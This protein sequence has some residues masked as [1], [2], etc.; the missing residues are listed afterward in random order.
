MS[1]DIHSESRIDT[2]V[3]PLERAR[4]LLDSS[5]EAPG[6][7]ALAHCVGLSPSHLQ[8]RFRARFGVS[9]AE[10][11]AA[12]KLGRFKRS[13]RDGNDVTTAVY[14]AGFGSGSRVYE[15]TDRLLGMT[16]A[17]Y[18]AGGADVAVRYTTLETPL[19]RLL[20]AATERGVCAVA[21]GANDAALLREL[22]DELPKARLDRVDEGSDDWLAAVIAHVFAQLGWGDAP[23]A[24]LPPLDLRASAFQWRVWQA[25]T[26]IP[27]GQTR[28]YSEIAHDIGAPRAARAVARACASN[29]L[30]VVVPCHRVIREDGS[31]GGYRWGM[32]RKRGLLA[33]EQRTSTSTV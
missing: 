23:A 15:H 25:L 22:R 20:V 9:P 7:E 27:A 4:E 8:R 31:L 6:L 12:K 17:R 16:P 29:R 3:D 1:L 26:R 28:S 24:A 21:L 5:E 19:G 33:S 14:E 30:A 13:L 10:Y 2:R 18:R 11:S 32:A